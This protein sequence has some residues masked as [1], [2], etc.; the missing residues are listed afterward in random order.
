[1]QENTLNSV[2][3]GKCFMDC[4]CTTSRTKGTTCS[5]HEGGQCSHVSCDAG[6]T[7]VKASDKD[8]AAV[9]QAGHKCVLEQKPT[10]KAGVTAAVSILML[11]IG[12]V[13]GGG[14]MFFFEKRFQ[15]KVRFAGYSNFGDDGM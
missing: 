8:S 7:L 6:Y 5:F 4:K 11:V 1:M 13:A 2:K 14:L 10:S 12:I 9:R 3:N 15:K